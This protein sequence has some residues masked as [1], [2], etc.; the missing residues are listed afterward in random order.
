MWTP[1]FSANRLWLRRKTVSSAFS[2][3]A[4]IDRGLKI[5]FRCRTSFVTTHCAPYK[6]TVRKSFTWS[7]TVVEV[8]VV[9]NAINFSRVITHTFYHC[10]LCVVYKYAAVLRRFGNNRMFINTDSGLYGGEGYIRCTPE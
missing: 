1:A 9:R 3:T 10:Y 6:H 7:T 5:Q 2:Y 8:I 4:G